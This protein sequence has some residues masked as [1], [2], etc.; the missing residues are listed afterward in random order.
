VGTGKGFIRLLPHWL[1]GVPEIFGAMVRV[2]DL[3]DDAQF[4]Q[5]GPIRTGAVGDDRDLVAGLSSHA[6]KLVRVDKNGLLRK[7]CL[8]LASCGATSRHKTCEVPGI[9]LLSEKGALIDVPMQV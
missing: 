4:C 2:H 6:A 8:I 3:R 5:A 7:N 9:S 1:G